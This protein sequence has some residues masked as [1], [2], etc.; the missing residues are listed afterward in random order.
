M[1]IILKNQLS[2]ICLIAVLSRA[3]AAVSRLFLVLMLNIF[4]GLNPVSKNI[5]LK[6]SSTSSRFQLLFLDTILCLVDVKKSYLL[7]WKC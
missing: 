2:I 6:F 1:Y 4:L 7:C 3:F 5:E